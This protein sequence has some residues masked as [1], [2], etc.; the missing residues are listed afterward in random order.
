MDIVHEQVRMGPLGPL[1]PLGLPGSVELVAP[2]EGLV[3][4]AHG[5]GSGSN[6]WSRRNQRVAELLHLHLHRRSTLLLDLLTPD[7]ATDRRK[8]FEEPGALETVAHQA[9]AWFVNHFSTTWRSCGAPIRRTKALVMMKLKVAVD[10][11]DPARGVIDVAARL[12]GEIGTAEVLLLNLRESAISKRHARARSASHR[13]RSLNPGL[14]GS[15]PHK[16]LHRSPPHRRRFRPV[17]CGPLAAGAHRPRRAAAAP[18][19]GSSTARWR[20]PGGPC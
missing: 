1:G 11:S 16:P 8:V 19:H 2:V 20:P 15:S 18:V 4:F 9:G 13:W 17:R 5:S 7:E 12:A 3:V 6:R 10:G 14:R